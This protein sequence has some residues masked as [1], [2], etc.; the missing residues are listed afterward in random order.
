MENVIRGGLRI[1]SGKFS[2]PVWKSRIF[3]GRCLFFNLKKSDDAILFLKE[4]LNLSSM[5]EDLVKNL[6]SSKKKQV[7]KVQHGM[8]EVL[9]L[10]SEGSKTERGD[11]PTG[12]MDTIDENAGEGR[13]SFP[14]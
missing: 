3:Y 6:D 8:R 11:P 14:L 12:T 5:V 1:P 10:T 4:M 9:S 2:T 13:A 7:E